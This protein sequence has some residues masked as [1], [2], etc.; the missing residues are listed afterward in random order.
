MHGGQKIF[1]KL[2]YQLP[3]VHLPMLK[4]FKRTFPTTPMS[5]IS[6]TSVYIHRICWTF[7]INCSVLMQCWQ[8][9]TIKRLTEPKV[10]EL[11]VTIFVQEKVVRFNIPEKKTSECKTKWT[12]EC[13][14]TTNPWHINTSMLRTCEYSDV[15]EWTQWPRHFG[16]CRI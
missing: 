11:H 9:C 16:Q 10:R 13:T 1:F 8:R 12:L 2:T 4:L 5:C 15:C 6:N 14:G 7:I 3:S